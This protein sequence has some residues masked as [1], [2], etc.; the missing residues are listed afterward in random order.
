MN[1]VYTL[2]CSYTYTYICCRYGYIHVQY[3]WKLLFPRSL[4]FDHGYAC[5]SHVDV[6]LDPKNLATVALYLTIVASAVFGF[7]YIHVMSHMYMV[8]EEGPRAGV[9]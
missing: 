2:T 8:W 3:M 9:G 1:R 6:F 5:V 7:R 4:C